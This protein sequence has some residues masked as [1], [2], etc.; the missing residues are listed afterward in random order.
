MAGA[1]SDICFSGEKF[2]MY[3]NKHFPVDILENDCFLAGVDMQRIQIHLPIKLNIISSSLVLTEIAIGW[4][5]R[6]ESELPKFK[7]AIQRY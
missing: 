6:A 1:A 7:N 5:R 4:K 3:F 2:G